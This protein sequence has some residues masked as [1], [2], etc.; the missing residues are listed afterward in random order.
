M[1]RKRKGRPIH[2]W[3]VIDKPQGITSSAAVTRVK[4]LTGAARV[5]H[6]GTLDPMATGVLPIALGEAT[7]TVAFAMDGVKRYRFTARWGEERTTDDAEGEVTETS[8]RRPTE[9]ELRNALPAF[10]GDIEQVPPAHSAVKVKG[11][12]AY[13]LAR[14]HAAVV[15]AP[16]RVRIERFDLLGMPDADRADFEVVA[17]KGAYMRSLIRDLARRLGTFGHVAALQ[18]IAVGPFSLERAISLENLQSLVHSSRL[19]EVLLPVE[20]VLVDI[21]ALALTE[22]EAG[23]MKRGEAV[24]LLGVATRSPLEGVQQDQVV[25]AMAAGRP[26]ALARVTGGEIR[27]FRVLNL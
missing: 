26:V 20:S 13:E 9:A 1:G 10:V 24:S 8:G 23:R 17:G 11:R 2:G 4:H 27:P 19:D 12:R 14:E 16:R 7:K 15:L 6:A 25:C 22:A 21:P 5:G 18:R 3:L